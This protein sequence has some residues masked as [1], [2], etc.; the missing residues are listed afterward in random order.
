MSCSKLFE[1]GWGLEGMLPHD[2]IVL[3]KGLLYCNEA[4]IIII[5]IVL[6]YNYTESIPVA[7]N[8]FPLI[9]THVSLS[10]PTLISLLMFFISTILYSLSITPAW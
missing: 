3:Y 8:F 5:S 9:Y 1:F 4:P 6:K 7:S 10:Y 2:F